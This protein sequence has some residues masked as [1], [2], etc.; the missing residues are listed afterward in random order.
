MSPSAGTD[1]N[2]LM[3]RAATGDELAFRS[4]YDSVS[5]AVL[6]FLLRMLN[7]RHEAEDILQDTM[8]IAWNRAAEFNPKLASAKTWITTIARRKAL[9]ILRRHNR[10]SDVLRS[11][12]ADIRQ[13]LNVEAQATSAENESGATMQKLMACFD[14]IGENAA[15]CIQHAYIDGMSASEI[16]KH[17]DRA[18]GSVKSWLRRGMI[19]LKTC[20]QR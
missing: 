15:T 7:D 12:A 18:L 14:K 16:A 2:D 9:D 19:N 3:Q 13:V 5:P 11:D 20:M 17:L 4:F 1:L 8:V 10:Q 6:G